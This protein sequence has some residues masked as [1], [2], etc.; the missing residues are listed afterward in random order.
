MKNTIRSAAVLL[1]LLLAACNNEYS[2]KGNSVTVRIADAPEGAP[3]MI[4][5]Q[6]LGDRIIRVSTPALP[7][8]SLLASPEERAASSAP[9]SRAA[10]RACLVVLPQ[11]GRIRF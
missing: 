8:E 3:Q 10:D 7:P 2:R 9:V 6:V 4:C 1:L 11:K 5:L